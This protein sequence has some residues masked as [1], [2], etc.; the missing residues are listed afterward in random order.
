VTARPLCKY[1]VPLCCVAD[2]QKTLAPQLAQAT[3]LSET[4]G[5]QVHWH[6]VLHGASQP[7]AI[8]HIDVELHEGAD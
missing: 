4:A 7:W 8:F 1:F 3:R 5:A 6:V 2:F